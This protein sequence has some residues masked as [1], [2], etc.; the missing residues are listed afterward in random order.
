MDATVVCPLP[1]QPHVVRATQG[2]G[3][4]AIAVPGNQAAGDRAALAI[5]HSGLA[6]PQHRVD[7]Q[8]TPSVADE[9]HPAADLSIALAVLLAEPRQRPARRIG[10]MAWG[11]LLFDGSLSGWD[12]PAEKLPSTPWIG[13][14]WRPDDRVPAYGSDAVISVVD[15]PTLA[16]AWDCLLR[17]LDIERDVFAS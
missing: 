4:P 11:A 15:V 5:K 13:R 17:L 16:I 14:V 3:A 10:W 8:I 12:A 2:S 6:L 1:S 7:V 9:L